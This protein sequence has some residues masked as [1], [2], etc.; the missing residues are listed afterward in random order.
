LSIAFAALFDDA[1]KLVADGVRAD[2]AA[3]IANASS[4]EL[5][6]AASSRGVKREAFLKLWLK[7]E[8]PLD[9]GPAHGNNDTIENLIEAVT[10]E[11]AHVAAGLQNYQENAI[12]PS[13]FVE[14]LID[15]SRPDHPTA[16]RAP[17]VLNGSFLPVL[18]VAH[19][20]ILSLVKDQPVQS[21]QIFLVNR[22]LSALRI[23]KVSFLPASR[24]HSGRGAPPRKPTYNY[25]ASL[26]A[27]DTRRNPILDPAPSSSLQPAAIASNSAIAADCNSRW[28]ATNL[29]LK[30]LKTVLNKTS[31]P[32]DYKLP[33]ESKSPYV[34]ETYRWVSINYDGAKPLHHL[35]LLVAIIVSNSLLPALFIPQ[36]LLHLFKNAGKENVH[37]IYH[38]VDW[39]SIKDRRG[40]SER[41]I[42]I[43]MFTTFIVALYE[44][45]SPLSLHLANPTNRGLGADWTT[46]HCSP[47]HPLSLRFY[48]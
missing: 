42:F 37:S 4:Q 32:I 27:R 33:T 39:I 6:R 1:R 36:K 14:S 34:N 40:M 45:K 31:L 16:A 20:A 43:S 11:P 41:G 17:V 26:G 3:A 21:Q 28:A 23:F 10:R 44:K 15:M 38:G 7:V 9:Y 46:K 48:F 35:A 25:W 30:T 29:T 18:K 24:P 13:T 22:F 12:A 47:P 2:I 5:I 19:L 8:F